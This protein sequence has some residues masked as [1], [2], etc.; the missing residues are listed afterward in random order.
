M[1]CIKFGQI[2][3]NCLFESNFLNLNKNKT[4]P[5]AWM[6]K[7]TAEAVRFKFV[8]YQ[9]CFNLSNCLNLCS[10]LSHYHESEN[11]KHCKN[12]KDCKTAIAGRRCRGYVRAV[13]LF[14][15]LFAGFLR[16][17]LRG[18]FRRFFAG[19]FGR[20]FTGFLRRLFCILVGSLDNCITFT[21]CECGVG[22][23]LISKFTFAAYD[24]PLIKFFAFGRFVSRNLYFRTGSKFTACFAISK[25]TVFNC[26]IVLNL[27]EY[28][29][30]CC[31]TDNGK[32]C[33]SVICVGNRSI[34]LIRFLRMY[35]S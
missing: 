14:G 30:Y 5:K 9:K 8:K 17:F 31:V 11:C 33:C 20:F 7:R 28:C 13:R 24:N 29:F 25:S 10:S 16:G 21:Y 26:K 23:R 35:L 3:F 18:F 32:G 22:V 12:Y 2:P 19:F 27:V 34:V 15:R 6:T 1:L 4:N